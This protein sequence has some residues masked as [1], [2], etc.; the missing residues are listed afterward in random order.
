MSRS[1]RLQLDRATGSDGPPGRGVHLL[2]VP[3]ARFTRAW[4]V[5]RGRQ[6]GPT[7]TMKFSI[8]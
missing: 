7:P 5:S 6:L 4:A 8:E 2:T 1:R 3:P